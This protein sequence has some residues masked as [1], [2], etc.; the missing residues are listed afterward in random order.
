MPS[1]IRDQAGTPTSRAVGVGRRVGLG[2]LAGVPIALLIG[3]TAAL[4]VP[5]QR[6]LGLWLAYLAGSLFACV[7]FGAFLGAMTVPRTWED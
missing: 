5:D 4:S 3:A 2:A 7:T 6:S 1:E